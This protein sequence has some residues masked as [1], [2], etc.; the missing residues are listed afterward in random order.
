[1]LIQKLKGLFQYEP[2]VLAWAINGGVALVIGYL[3]P[4]TATQAAAVTL[5]TTALAT[6]YTA[7]KARPIVVSAVTGALATALTAVAAFG[8]DFSSASIANVVAVAGG[9]L[10]LLFRANLTPA[11]KLTK[12]VPAVV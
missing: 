11:I 7:V 4:L 3:T 9:L 12:R 5:I 8:L 1:M 10:G 2:A 6:I